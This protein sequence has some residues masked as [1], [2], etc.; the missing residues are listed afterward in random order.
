MTDTLQELARHY[1][2]KLRCVAERHGLGT[3]LDRVIDENERGE[4]EATEKECEILARACDE[5]RISRGEIPEL[6]G[7]SYRRCVEEGVFDAIKKL[8]HVGIYSRIGAILHKK[9][10]KN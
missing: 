7:M 1:L 5:E 6:F 2:R 4:C 9:R 3:W 10:K 8:R